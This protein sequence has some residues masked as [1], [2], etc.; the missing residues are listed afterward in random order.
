MKPD[1]PPV[2]ETKKIDSNIELENETSE[3]VKAWSHDF[4]QDIYDNKTE[5]GVLFRSA[6]SI[7][8]NT[9]LDLVKNGKTEEDKKL[10]NSRRRM[11][12]SIFIETMISFVEEKAINIDEKNKLDLFI[13]NIQE[14]MFSFSPNIFNSINLEDMVILSAKANRVP[15]VQGWFGQ[16]MVGEIVYELNWPPED[17]ENKVVSK[18]LKLSTAEI[19]DILEQLEVTGARA[20]GEMYDA[21][22]AFDKVVNIINSIKVHKNSPIINYV[23]ELV[24]ERLGNEE[25]NPSLGFLTYNGEKGRSRLNKQRSE[26][27]NKESYKISH[28]INPNIHIDGLILPIASDA[29]ASFDHSNTPRYFSVADYKNFAP[30]QELSII[31][32]KRIL[33]LFQYN[34]NSLDENKA[35]GYINK[36]IL[37]PLGKK[38]ITSFKEFGVENIIN[39]L[40]TI[41]ND[42]EKET[43]HTHFDKYNTILNNKTL[44]PFVNDKEDNQFG[45]LLQHL[46]KPEL[47]NKI[48]QDL[49]I[50]L[51]EIPLRSQIHFL[52]FL[53][54][55]DKNR[56]IKLKKIL[57]NKES[58]EN[59]AF[60]KSFLSMS[61]DSSMGDKILALGEKLPEEAAKVLFAKYGEYIDAVNNVEDVVNKEYK[62]PPSPELIN[63]TKESL[64]IRGRDLLL[65]QNKKLSDGEFSEKKFSESL[66]NTKVGVDLFKNIF[67]IT[68]ENNPDTSFEDFAGL[69][70]EQV[71][72]REQIKDEDILNI[73]KIIDKNYPNKE[74]RKAVKESFHQ[75]LESNKTVLNLLRRDKNIIALDRIDQKE[76]GT[77]YFGSFNVDPDYCSSKIGAAFFEATVLPLMKE[78]I[79][80]ADCSSLQPIASYYIESGFIANSLYDYNGESS[81][82]LE[83]IPGKTFISK[84]LSKSQIIESFEKNENSDGLIIKSAS[85]Q[86]EITEN[87][88]PEGYALTRYFLDKNTNKWYVVLEK[89]N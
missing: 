63:K 79:V 20:S 78:K 10:K 54:I 88:I 40:S 43:T 32:I 9:V 36:A 59:M 50:N 39:E 75:A 64:L 65:A 8:E 25:N 56:F 45:L 71:N 49:Q 16:T 77:L 33:Y 86:K 62:L 84:D 11:G 53:S 6:D 41:I 48:E 22:N 31:S 17:I 80:K 87:K 12:I 14:S 89:I 34:F 81:F 30:P 51:N 13:N 5:L 61:G 29:I 69:V 35:V 26:D 19:L 52:K 72:S 60:L 70:P 73:D 83:S 28:Q 21:S 2:L 3:K 37:G 1:M 42:L 7:V 46:H 74:L 82:S 66:D 76:D 47:R 85:S 67:R 57:E 58:I 24:L 23:S 55:S 4:F 15:E 27:M 68:K 38:E 44:N 18:I